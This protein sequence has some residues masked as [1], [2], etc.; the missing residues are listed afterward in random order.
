MTNEQLRH[1]LSL[2]DQINHVTE[3]LARSEALKR[4][5]QDTLSIGGK[6][7]TVMLSSPSHCFEEV[8]EKIIDLLIT[9]FTDRLT[10]L[11]K[12]FGSL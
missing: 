10:E 1:A 4:F 12:E 7:I 3:D 6:N 8:R 11:Q 9:A 2:T 5:K